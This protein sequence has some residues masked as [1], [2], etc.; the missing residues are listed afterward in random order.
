MF[1]FSSVTKVLNFFQNYWGG[2]EAKPASNL[3]DSPSDSETV[4]DAY[5][6]AEPKALGFSYEGRPTL[7]KWR[8]DFAAIQEENGLGVSGQSWTQLQDL[9]IQL[10]DADVRGDL[11]PEDYGLLL[12]VDE[13]KKDLD[14]KKTELLEKAWEVVQSKYQ[15]DL[16][17][18][19]GN[20]FARK[21]ADQIVED[22]RGSVL[23]TPE[24]KAP[25]LALKI[26]SIV[27]HEGISEAEVRKAVELL[28]EL[29]DPK[30][31]DKV[32]QDLEPFLLFGRQPNLPLKNST[33]ERFEFYVKAVTR[34]KRESLF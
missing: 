32:W 7:S 17:L 11:S 8:Q 6:L 12:E 31:G 9:E 23:Y 2:E 26:A 18:E 29:K 4:G 19:S 14:E 34:P 24:E 15:E 20:I 21:L 10:I 3:S 30:Y 25:F 13:A 27:S 28:L 1:D 5:A 16:S 33:E 22:L